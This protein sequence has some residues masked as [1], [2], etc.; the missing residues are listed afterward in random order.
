MIT[1]ESGKPGKP[2]VPG[3]SEDS[4]DRV[5]GMDRDISRRDFLN[6]VAM[7]AGSLALPETGLA[8]GRGG[9]AAATAPGEDYPYPPMR[10]GIRGSQ[11]GSYI[12]AHALRDR[13]SVDLARA[14][15]TGETYDLV[16]V[17]GGLSGLAAAHFFHKSV[18]RGARVLILDNHDDVGGHARRNEFHYQGRT[19]VLN[20]GTFDIESPDRYNQW[21]RQ[22]LDEIGAD[23]PRYVAANRRNAAL[24]ASLGLRSGYFF[25]RETFGK[26]RLVVAP[27]APARQSRVPLTEE[28]LRGMP[29]SE[30]ARQDLRRLQDP[31]QP[32]YFAG[33][34]QGEKKER[35][36]RMSYK[37]YLLQVAKVDS[38]AYWFYMA[39]GRDVFGVGAD[40]TPA[41]FAWVMGG[42]GFAG[43]RLEPLPEGLLADLPGGQHGR[44]R[45]GNADV[46][47]PDGNATLVRLLLRRLIPAAVPGTTLEDVGM[48]RVDYALLDRPSSAT[49]IRLNSTVLN[50]RHDGDAAS[51]KE[52]I[53]S[54][55][56]SGVASGKL[57]DVRARAC[58]MASWNMMIPYVIPELPAE[59]KAALS[60]NV[61][62]PIVY[63]SVCVRN[64]RAFEK[65]GI[66]SVKCPT[67]YHD[68][69][70]LPE[71]VDLGEL[72]HS[73]SPQEPIVLSLTRYPNVP[74]LPR[75]EQHRAGRAELLSTT[76]E[77]F[78]RNIRDQLARILSPGGFDPR[79]DIV[80]IMVNRWGHGYSYT[81]NS[82]YDPLDWVFTETASRPCVKARQPYGLITIANADAA[83]SPHTDA[84]FLT[85]HWA[86]EQVLSK[87]AFPFV[88]Q[89]TKA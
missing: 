32:D 43:L 2:L 57:Y 35:L 4:S 58:V 84:A 80:G 49:R 31:A 86:V 60:D 7:V 48:A 10:T 77:T 8:A 62:A 75:K 87:R 30:R 41:L 6:G 5:L 52:L 15:H 68:T 44:Q 24:Y 25:E 16:I 12:A 72:R 47:F 85:A 71:P 53:V 23:L 56:P 81:Y 88:A 34:G 45:P 51:A 66:S 14:E 54:Y 21:A 13:R 69:V 39:L 55:S 61:K 78:E 76:F 59:Q 67:M 82:L 11:P 37:D 42:D 9:S 26:D 1:D 70:A 64:W 18:G 19:L 63:T 73:A 29:I 38:Q 83:A 22:V 33:L 46:H 65:L 20:G 74:G 79:R 50:V 40:A 3:K 17:G 89:N 36:A 27:A 28:Y